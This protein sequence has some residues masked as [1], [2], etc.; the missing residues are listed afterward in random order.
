[1]WIK[2]F[3]LSKNDKHGSQNVKIDSG[4]DMGNPVQLTDGHPRSCSA[5]DAPVD[6]PTALFRHAGVLH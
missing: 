3:K 6:T 5:R 1:L 4:H 2:F